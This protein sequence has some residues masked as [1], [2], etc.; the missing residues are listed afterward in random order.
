M[1][2]RSGG[3]QKGGSQHGRGAKFPQFAHPARGSGDTDGSQSFREGP[4]ASQRGEK[5]WSTVKFWRS[6]PRHSRDV[7]GQPLDLVGHGLLSGAYASWNEDP[8]HSVPA[9]VTQQARQARLHSTEICVMA[10]ARLQTEAFWSGLIRVNFPGMEIKYRCLPI[11]P[12]EPIDRPFGIGIREE[13]KVSP[14]AAGQVPVGQFDR[15][16]RHFEKLR[17]R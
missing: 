4:S 15:R 5:M 16:D 7:F 10:H 3:C 1:A 14:T 11:V 2:S 17:V 6:D 12:I 13:P 9:K 8:V